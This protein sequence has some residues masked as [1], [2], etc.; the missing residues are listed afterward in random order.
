[1]LIL[2]I[3]LPVA[4]ASGA[5]WF[6]FRSYDIWQMNR[7]V[8]LVL[9][10]VGLVVISCT[11]VILLDWVT[12][13]KRKAYLK[14]GGKLVGSPLTQ[15]VK[16][17]LGGV[18]IPLA[19]FAVAMLANTPLGGTAMDLFVRTSQPTALSGPAEQIASLVIQ[20]RDPLTQRLGIQAL[21][22]LQ[23]PRGLGQLVRVLNEGG[24]LLS[25]AGLVDALSKAIASYGVEAKGPLL[26]AFNKA[27]PSIRNKPS[28][29]REDFFT[30]YFAASFV[31]LRNEIRNQ[32][33]T[34]D[35]HEERLAR[36]DAA[37]A[38]LK[39]ILTDLWVECF[40]SMG[41]DLRLDVVLRTFLSM[42]VNKNADL[43]HFAKT[44]AA[45]TGYPGSV[46]GDALLLI[47]K[48]GSRDEFAILYSYLLSDNRVLQ[49]RALEA[50]ISLQSK[51]AK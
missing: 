16:F 42:N 22:G 31:G 11:L 41:A 32:N 29:L 27:A 43:L 9:L 18:V 12:S 19:L 40:K 49:K 25:D 36:V 39:K 6:L 15:L 51:T 35:N 47:G 17:V 38:Q 20:S 24:D 10:A 4:I 26:E 2:E 34:P 14:Q 45:D 5:L 30:R 33:E 23:S 1:L 28:G 48:L 46:R 13:S 8:A 3:I 50:T 44:I 21:A 7:T 37:E